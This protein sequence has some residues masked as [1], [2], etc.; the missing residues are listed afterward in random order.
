MN[1][2]ESAAIPYRHARKPLAQRLPPRRR[3]TASLSPSD[4]ADLDNALPAARTH[5]R[6]P[7]EY[8]VPIHGRLAAPKGLPVRFVEFSAATA[9]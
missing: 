9:L 7:V 4:I 6:H 8:A 1:E 5:C 3:A 2:I